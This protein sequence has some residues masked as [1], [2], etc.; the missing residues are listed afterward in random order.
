MGAD[1]PLYRKY[2]VLRTD[3]MDLPGRKHDDCDLF[4]LDLTH[5][6]AAKPAILAYA[7]AV[8]ETH[9]I[10]AAELRERFS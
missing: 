9:P 8:S 7:D 3:G 4:V 2:H 1:G 10:L 6:P 5:D